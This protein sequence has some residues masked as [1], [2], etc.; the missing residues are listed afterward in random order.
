[1]T[2]TEYNGHKNKFFFREPLFAASPFR[3]LRPILKEL[4]IMIA[5]FTPPSIRILHDFMPFRDV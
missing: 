2:D 1:M 4:F 5:L 3:F